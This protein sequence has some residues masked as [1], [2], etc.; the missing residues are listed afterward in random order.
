MLL[1]LK[2][3]PALVVHIILKQQ[4]GLLFQLTVSQTGAEIIGRMMQNGMV[5]VLV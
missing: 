4:L 5:L 1:F 3:P 2:P